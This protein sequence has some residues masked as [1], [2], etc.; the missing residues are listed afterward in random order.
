MRIN[1]PTYFRK[2]ECFQFC[3]SC[4]NH[5]YEFVIFSMEMRTMNKNHT[6]NCTHIYICIIYVCLRVGTVR[7]I[8]LFSKSQFKNINICV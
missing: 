2:G 4:M 5:S 7:V 3:K 8:S 6:T 1:L